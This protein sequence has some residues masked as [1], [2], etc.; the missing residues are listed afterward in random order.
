M[1][2]RNYKYCGLDIFILNLTI[3]TNKNIF[4]VQIYFMEVV[5]YNKNLP[6]LFIKEY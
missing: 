1:I 6:L 3:D 4:Y 2:R 5:N